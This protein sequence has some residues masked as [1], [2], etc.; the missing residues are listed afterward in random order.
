MFLLREINEDEQEFEIGYFKPNG[1][2]YCVDTLR[3]P[4]AYHLVSYLNGGSGWH[5]GCEG[6]T[7]D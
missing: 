7:E 3:Y 4:S 6:D 1:D 5:S 2:W